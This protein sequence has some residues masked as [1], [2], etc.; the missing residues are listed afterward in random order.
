MPTL[1]NTPR[2]TLQRY[3]LFGVSKYFHENSIWGIISRYYRDIFQALNWSKIFVICNCFQVN[4]RPKL[5]NIRHKKYHLNIAIFSDYRNMPYFQMMQN[6]AFTIYCDTKHSS[7]TKTLYIAKHGQYLSCLSLINLMFQI[8]FHN[9]CQEFLRHQNTNNLRRHLFDD[10]SIGQLYSIHQST[11]S[12]QFWSFHICPKTIQSISKSRSNLS[13]LLADRHPL[14]L[15]P[16]R[17][18]PWTGSARPAGLQSLHSQRSPLL[19][20]SILIKDHQLKSGGQIIFIKNYGSYLRSRRTSERII[21]LLYTWL[22]W[23]SL[24]AFQLKWSKYLLTFK[25]FSHV[26][27]NLHHLTSK[28]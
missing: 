13:S 21:H 19:T 12:L 8:M 5:I 28:P 27:L 3:C 15:Q 4:K 9:C 1:S 17:H 16:G 6:I 10:S 18:C 7:L 25:A 23:A 20:G 24:F 11:S 22:I 26:V 14:P 2:T